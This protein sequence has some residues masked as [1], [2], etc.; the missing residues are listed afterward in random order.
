MRILI[1]SDTHGSLRNFDIVIEREKEIDMLLHLGDVE[2]DNDYMEAVMNCPV[3]IVGGNNDYFSGLPG[4]IELRI[5]KYKVF[6]THGHGYYVSMDTRR[7]KQAARARGADIAMYGHTHRPDIDLEDG[8][9]VINPG[10]LSYP[11]QSGRQATYIIME[12]NTEGEVE[13]TLK[14]V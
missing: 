5:G 1:V 13:F 4:E 3:H 9:K 6:M 2:G 10:S 12:V 11:R 8:V 7:L 14:H